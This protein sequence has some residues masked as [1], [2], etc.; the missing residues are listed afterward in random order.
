M[1]QKILLLNHISAIMFFLSSFSLLGIP[2]LNL[3]NEIPV[4]GYLIAVIFWLCLLSG[5]VLQI[6]IA[7][8]AK[9]IET[10]R[11]QKEKRIFIITAFFLVLFILLVRF[12]EKNI[13]LM[14]IDIA[15]LLFSIEMYFCLKWR[16]SI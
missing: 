6:F 4:S 10:K 15:F 2:F 5:V 3:E 16:Y 12:F 14:S 8:M 9:K 13:L 1:K 7:L 11:T